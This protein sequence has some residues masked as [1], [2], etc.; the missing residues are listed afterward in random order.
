MSSLLNKFVSKTEFNSYEDFEKNFMIEVPEN[1]NFSYDVVDKYAEIN[2]EKVAM[3]WCDDTS[4]RIF[5]FKDMKFY[6]DKAANLFKEAGITKGQSVMLT[7][8]SRFEFWFCLLG[9]NKIGAIPIPATHMLKPR[10]IV[11][12]IKN[13]DIKMIVCI[14]EDQVPECVD[15]AEKNLEN[16]KIIKAM[17]GGEERKGW[18]NFTQDLEKASEIF[19]RPTGK[20]S[21]E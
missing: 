10:D 5:T 14:A 8:K 2:P 4:E 21:T 6:S 3:V 1:F 12:R 20:H 9:L 13:A 18:I 11:Y 16:K 7:L 19:E 15:E 17:V